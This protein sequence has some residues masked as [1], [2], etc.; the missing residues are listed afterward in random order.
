MRTPD[1]N[2]FNIEKSKYDFIYEN[3]RKDDAF[4]FYPQNNENFH[5]NEEHNL[6]FFKENNLKNNGS[7][8][9]INE[10]CNH[11]P[12]QAFNKKQ[13]IISEKLKIDQITRESEF[14]QKKI[15]LTDRIRE[16]ILKKEEIRKNPNP[17]QMNKRQI[18]LN[19]EIFEEEDLVFPIPSVSPRIDSKR[20]LFGKENK[21]NLA[22]NNKLDNFGN[23]NDFKEKNIN[24]SFD[25]FS[26][27]KNNDKNNFEQN[28]ESRKNENHK[29]SISLHIDVNK[30]TDN[31][32]NFLNDNNNKTNRNEGKVNNEEKNNFAKNFSV[33][34]DENQKNK[35]NRSFLEYINEKIFSSNFEGDITVKKRG[36]N[37]LDRVKIED[38]LIL[39]ND[40][41]KKRELMA[42]ITE[43]SKNGNSKSWRKLFFLLGNLVE[44]NN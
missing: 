25:E 5:N 20:L 1:E 34:L 39:E 24:I 38:S 2:T 29:K 8:L 15:A 19:E 17:F 27:E 42:V 9:I 31:F 14:N 12:N 35:N 40:N 41:G 28:L 44:N 30:F 18:N 3:N 26:K 6:S 21:P 32:A 7:K 10:R 37:L 36:L 16:K 22:N 13:T 4:N 33:F 11:E 43:M 23:F